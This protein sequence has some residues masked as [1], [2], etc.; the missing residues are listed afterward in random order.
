MESRYTE[1]TSWAVKS[2]G[3][4]DDARSLPP[5]HAL[6]HLLPSRA[7]L[8]VYLTLCLFW[9]II[10]IYSFVVNHPYLRSTNLRKWLR[11]DFTKL[12]LVCVRYL[13]WAATHQLSLPM[14]SI[15]KPILTSPLFVG[16]SIPDFSPCSSPRQVTQAKSL[17]FQKFS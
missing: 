5:W 6:L 12:Q 9:E 10:R 15:W 3:S 16:H 14:N 4:S 1:A 11:I 17:K 13:V 7:H 2:C 8:S